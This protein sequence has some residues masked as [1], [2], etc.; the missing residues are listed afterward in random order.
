MLSPLPR[1]DA[2]THDLAPALGNLLDGTRLVA[3]DLTLMSEAAASV[4]AAGIPVVDSESIWPD[5]SAFR[6]ARVS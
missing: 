3:G 1:A 2:A 4:S 5:R 6:M